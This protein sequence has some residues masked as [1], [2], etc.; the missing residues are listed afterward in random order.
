[1]VEAIDTTGRNYGRLYWF[2]LDVSEWYIEN[3]HQRSGMGRTGEEIYNFF[4][5]HMSNL[6]SNDY[7]KLL[8]QNNFSRL[9]E[10]QLN[11]L[12]PS[13]ERIRVEDLDLTLCFKIINLLRGREISRLTEFVVAERNKLC[14]PSMEMPHSPFTQEK[15]EDEFLMMF[16]YLESYG[17][18]RDIMVTC[19]INIGM[20]I[21][22]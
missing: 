6:Y 11:A 8:S 7:R 5:E 17:V 13:D 15:F 12:N 19:G 10:R 18:N 1:M 3:F 2:L 22:S 9:S 4:H 14:H 20:T 21:T 16:H